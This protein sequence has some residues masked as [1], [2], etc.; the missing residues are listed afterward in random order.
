[1]SLTRVVETC[2]KNKLV[3]GPP[4]PLG[5][6]QGGFSGVSARVGAARVWNGVAESLAGFSAIAALWDPKAA[7]VRST[8]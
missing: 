5:E 3:V 8:S 7:G 1:M 4:G 2:R 6:S